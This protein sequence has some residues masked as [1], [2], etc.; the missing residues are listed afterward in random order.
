MK[1]CNFKVL[2]EYEFTDFARIVDIYGQG[3]NYPT[4]RGVDGFQVDFLIKVKG[5]EFNIS[6][7]SEDRT[8]NMYTYHG[9]E[10]TTSSKYGNDGDESEK[11]IKFC[12]KNDLNYEEVL[13][14]LQK[15]AE[16]LCEEYYEYFEK[17][18]QY[19]EESDDDDVDDDE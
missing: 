10:M 3:C 4:G 9:F 5:K 18:V 17:K 6:F 19:E 16:E 15:R 11:F 7:Q 13:D 12:L 2:S 1:K 14:T 8:D